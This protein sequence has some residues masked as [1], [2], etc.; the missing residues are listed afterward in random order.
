MIHPYFS[1]RR[2]PEPAY[3]GSPGPSGILHRAAALFPRGGA[4]SPRS[5]AD[6]QILCPDG[7]RHNQAFTP[8]SFPGAR[9]PESQTHTAFPPWSPSPA[10]TE[11]GPTPGSVFPQDRAA[12]LCSSRCSLSRSRRRS[13]GPRHN[14]LRRLIGKGLVFEPGQH[15]VE[16]LLYAVPLLLQPARSASLSTSSSIGIL[17]VASGVTMLTAPADRSR[18]PQEPPT[19]RP[20]AA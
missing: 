4:A 5:R 11:P 16:L 17:M 8:A 12:R 18:S 19:P 14:G 6:S 10:K 1:C 9:I 7:S 13:P 3:Q 15:A 20:G 2:Q